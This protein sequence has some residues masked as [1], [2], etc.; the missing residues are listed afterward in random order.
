MEKAIFFSLLTIFALLGVHKAVELVQGLFTLHLRNT[1]IVMY[2]PPQSCD[3]AEMV[4]RQLAQYSKQISAPAKTAVYIVKDDL[5]EKSLE[6]CSRTADQYGNV[7]VGNFADA[8]E[9][10]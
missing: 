5:D 9:F 8:N 2:K 6:L 7:F 3:D 1:V 10:L 4:I